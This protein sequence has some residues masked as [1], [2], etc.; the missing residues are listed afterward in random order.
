VL[1]YDPFRSKN[2]TISC[3]SCHS[4]YTAF[5]HVDH[6][7]SHGIVYR[8]GNRNAP[9][10][11]NLAWHSSFIWDG[12]IHHLDFQSLAPIENHN[13]MD[14]KIGYIILKLNQQTLYKKLFYNAM[15]IIYQLA[16]RL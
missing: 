6:A 7:L 11:M 10:L 13:E 4:Q 3:A 16:K 8:I 14:E 2:N 15:A 1:F 9:A 12:A 5:T